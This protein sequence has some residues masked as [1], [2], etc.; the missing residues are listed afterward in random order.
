[1]NRKHIIKGTSTVLFAFLS[2]CAVSPIH[3]GD[4]ETSNLP[5]VWGNDDRQDLYQVTDPELKSDADAVVAVMPDYYLADQGDG[6]MK[7]TVTSPYLRARIAS[8][9]PY[10]SLCD[11]E[12]FKGQPKNGASCTGTLVGPRMILTASHCID[13]GPLSYRFVFGYR[14][15]DAQTPNLAVPAS[16]VYQPARV[17]ARDEAADWALVELTRPVTDHRIVNVRRSG[18]VADGQTVHLAGHPVGLPIK[19]ATNGQVQKNTDAKYFWASLDAFAGN[20]GSSVINSVTHEIEGIYVA[21]WFDYELGYPTLPDD[22]ER[23]CLVSAHC[24]SIADCGNNQMSVRSSEFASSVP[25]PDSGTYG[26]WSAC[27]GTGFYVCTEY[28]AGYSSY[29]ANH[30]NCKPNPY[31]AGQ[32]YTCSEACPAPTESDR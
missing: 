1:V 4:S 17:V 30:P 18:K 24:N 32:H 29:F 31:C 26:Q 14:M 3:E 20:S 12:P 28:L 25:R 16:Q 6:S 23:N 7:I 10:F 9:L 27:R 11:W 22:P 13:G 19:V 15:L 5:L 2:G 21:G 8:G